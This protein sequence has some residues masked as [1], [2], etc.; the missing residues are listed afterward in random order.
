MSALLKYEENVTY[1]LNQIKYSKCI[2]NLKNIGSKDDL[3]KVKDSFLE[4]KDFKSSSEYIGK[5]DELLKEYEEN[6]NRTTELNKQ[7]IELSRA[8]SDA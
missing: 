7:I 5:I 1:S 8:K 4:I 6:E 3:L 2:E